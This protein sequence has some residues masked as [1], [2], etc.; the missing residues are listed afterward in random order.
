MRNVLYVLDDLRRASGGGLQHLYANN[1]Y[2]Q[3]PSDDEH[4][5]HGYV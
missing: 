1:S 3:A 2:C 4:G 5:G